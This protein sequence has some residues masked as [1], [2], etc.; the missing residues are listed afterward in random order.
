MYY[1][2]I[3]FILRTLIIMV[4]GVYKFYFADID[5]NGRRGLSMS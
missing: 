2:V 4:V 1:T 3:L 5:N